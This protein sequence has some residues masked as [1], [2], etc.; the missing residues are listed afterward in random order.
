MAIVTVAQALKKLY[1]TIVGEDTKKNNPTKIIVELADHWP[2][3]GGGSGSGSSDY[4][5]AQVTVNDTA[6]LYSALGTR[7]GNTIISP[8]E[9]NGSGTYTVVLY[10]G[11]AGATA[12]P[13]TP[14]S[15]N[16][17]AFGEDGSFI[18]TGDCTIGDD[19]GEHIA[20]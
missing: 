16:I 5:T 18:I 3:T 12:D 14:I 20:E 7:G 8:V 17:E 6:T 4:S 1:K 2:G 13:S 10:Q 11:K 9:V 19:D 15:G